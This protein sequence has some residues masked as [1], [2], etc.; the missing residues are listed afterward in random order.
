VSAL[1]SAAS[2]EGSTHAAPAPC[3]NF[4]AT[5]GTVDAAAAQLID[6]ATKTNNPTRMICKRPYRSVSIR[7]G[8]SKEARASRGALAIHWSC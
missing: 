6:A 3:A 4:A 1:R 2:A 5:N 8:T 7:A